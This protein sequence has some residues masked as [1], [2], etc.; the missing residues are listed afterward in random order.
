MLIGRTSIL[1]S[2]PFPSLFHLTE[3][4]ILCSGAQ[5]FNLSSPWE[6]H[7]S[8][9]LE[10]IK[11]TNKP[12]RGSQ[13]IWFRCECDTGKF[14]WR[15]WYFYWDLPLYVCKYWYLNW[16]SFLLLSFQTLWCV[17][18]LIEVVG[19]HVA[20]TTSKLHHTCLVEC[21]CN[22]ERFLHKQSRPNKGGVPVAF[23]LKSSNNRNWNYMIFF[24]YWLAT[25]NRL[26]YL[27][28]RYNVSAYHLTIVIT[29]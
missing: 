11:H 25:A 26:I 24:I 21:C 12:Q 5:G 4:H 19:A 10:T 27:E 18:V 17:N 8:S 22:T 14:F 15:A 29:N 16:Y 7:Y 2:D 1:V 20:R 3:G 6:A 13:D 23:K 9:R 28:V